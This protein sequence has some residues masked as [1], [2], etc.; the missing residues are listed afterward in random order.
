MVFESDLFL[1]GVEFEVYLLLVDF[2][3]EWVDME[4]VW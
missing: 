3:F 2:G 1:G 4:V